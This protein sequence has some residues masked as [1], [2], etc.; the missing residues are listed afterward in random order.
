MMN[1]SNSGRRWP[2]SAW[3]LL[4]PIV[5]AL[6]LSAGCA[7]RR[8]ERALRRAQALEQDRRAAQAREQLSEIVRRWP[9]TRA[10]QRAR[11]EIEWLDDLDQGVQRGRVLLVWDAVRRVSHAAEAFR[12]ARGRYPERFD[13]LVPVFVPGPVLDPWGHPVGYLR[14]KD[15][16]QAIS[17]GSDGIPGG[18]GDAADLLV[19]NGQVVLPDDRARR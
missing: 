9:K 8:A 17:F 3:L 19:Q 16:Y 15:G 12:L 4:A 18:S 5:L 1:S 7:E 13:E 10:A 11:L 2:M 6:V 14:T